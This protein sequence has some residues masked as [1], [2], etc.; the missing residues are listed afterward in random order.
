M[1]KK[2]QKWIALLVVFTFMWLLQVSTMPL[3]AAGT[4]EQVSSANSEQG[5]RFIEEEGSSGYHAPKKSILP[6]VLIGVGV[7]AVAAVLFLVV[8]K[9]NYDI[10]GS[11]TVNIT[12][13][14]DPNGDDKWYETVVFNGG[15]ESGTTLDDW[16]GTGTY[17][18]NGKN[19]T[20]NLRWG[21]NNTST[22]TG[23]FDG[24]DNMSGTFHE[25]NDFDGSWTAVR[26]AAGASLPKFKNSATNKG[27]NRQ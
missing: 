13:D 19:V 27:P 23:Q 15:K 8:L 7:V 9:T 10:V 26:G 12:Y 18:V 3:A 17:T 11:W 21:N 22:F 16:Y 20:F 1:I 6:Y 5:P 25:S 4:A 2:Q 14:D 24:K